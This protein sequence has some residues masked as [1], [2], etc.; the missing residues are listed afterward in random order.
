MRAFHGL[1]PRVARLAGKGQP[2]AVACG[3][4]PH[5]S[6]ITTF[7]RPTIWVLT[8]PPTLVSPITHTSTL[9]HVQVCTHTHTRGNSLLATTILT[10]ICECLIHSCSIPSSFAHVWRC[11]LSERYLGTCA[12][13][14]YYTTPVTP[15]EAWPYR[16]NTHLLLGWQSSR[17]LLSTFFFLS[18]WQHTANEVLSMNLRMHII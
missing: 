5:S 3:T 4:F 10:H 9:T 8:R 1:S 7:V 15:R 14:F 6:V 17:S 13:C 16:G 2:F 12:T 11:C 18:E